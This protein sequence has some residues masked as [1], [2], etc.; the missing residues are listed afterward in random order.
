MGGEGAF[1]DKIVSSI[2]QGKAVDR[3][4][5]NSRVLSD[6]KETFFNGDPEYFQSQ[7]QAW[8]KQ[9]G[10]TSKDL[11]NTSLSALLVRMIAETT[12]GTVKSAMRRALQLANDKGLAEKTA[13]EI[14]E[15]HTA[16][17]KA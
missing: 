13:A 4:V 9:F 11:N 7:F 5:Q 6:V 3:A 15:K 2:T 16:K 10:L 1:F 17:T 8:V 12:D 14:L